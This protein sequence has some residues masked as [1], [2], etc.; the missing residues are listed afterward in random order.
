MEVLKTRS[1]C[2]DFGQ[3]LGKI[4]DQVFGQVFDKVFGQ[5]FDQGF[6][7]RKYS[8]QFYQEEEHDQKKN[9][10]KQLVRNK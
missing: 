1:A 9:N 2:P 3:I 4:F 10:Y 6:W 5:I 8:V 7:N